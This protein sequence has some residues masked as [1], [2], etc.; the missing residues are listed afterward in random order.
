MQVERRK[1]DEMRLPEKITYTLPPCDASTMKIVTK[2]INESLT[3]E[4][5]LETGQLNVQLSV[6]SNHFC[7]WKPT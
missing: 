7:R 5:L 4:T 6:V 1:I 3:G 2:M